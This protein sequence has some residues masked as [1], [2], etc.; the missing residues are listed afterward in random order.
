MRRI[1]HDHDAMAVRDRLQR[2]HVTSP[3]VYLNRHDGFSARRDFRLHR[4]GIQ[5]EIGTDIR[6]YRRGADEMN[7]CRGGY[8][9][10]RR[11][12][13]LIAGTDSHGAQTQP[14]RVRTV[15]HAK[16]M[17][18]AHEGGQVFLKIHQVLLQNKRATTANVKN[19]L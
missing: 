10:M 9:C 12:N 14:Y 16:S 3:P 7:R 13:H 17:F 11:E 8:V 5:H 18:N 19:N 1:F 15:G 2:V 4:S 6:Q